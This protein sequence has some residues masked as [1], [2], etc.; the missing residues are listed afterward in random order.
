M[1][2][3]GNLVFSSMDSLT[4]RTLLE[5]FILIALIEFIGIMINWTNRG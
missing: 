5:Y 3:I 2:E 1:E 4:P